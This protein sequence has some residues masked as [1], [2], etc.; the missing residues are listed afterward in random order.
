MGVAALVWK[1]RNKET[2]I[3]TQPWVSVNRSVKLCYHSVTK[4]AI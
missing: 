1:E 4:A 2:Q 3:K